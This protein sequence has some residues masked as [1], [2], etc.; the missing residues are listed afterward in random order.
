LDQALLRKTRARKRATT[1]RP[2]AAERNS[3]GSRK[4]VAAVFL[5]GFM[6]AGKTSVGRTLGTRLNWSFEDLDERI[7]RLEGRR[8]AEIFRE[9]GEAEFRRAEHNAL[10]SVLSELQ[11]GAVRIVA[12]GGGAFV[13]EENAALLKGAKV[14]TVYLDAPVTE[15]WRRC[16]EQASTSG[17]Q[18]PLLQN[19]GQF[20][21]LHQ[22]R[23]E[24]YAKASHRIQTG[25]R[26]MEE[27]AAEIERTLGLKKMPLREEQGEVE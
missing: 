18:R 12:L 1:T 20:K 21:K 9:A 15:L 17:A 8:V 24:S 7:E 25:K 19:E 26:S 13:R 16:C 23:R 11:S 27:I 22:E 14:A 5:V 10:R 6:G 4:S 3:Q 2:E